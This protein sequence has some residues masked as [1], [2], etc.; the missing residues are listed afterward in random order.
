MT[1]QT[2]RG[3][4]AGSRAGEG[5]PAGAARVGGAALQ[6]QL[7]GLLVSQEQTTGRTRS[8]HCRQFRFFPCSTP[9]HSVPA[10]AAMHPAFRLCWIALLV[11]PPASAL[12]MGYGTSRRQRHGHGAGPMMIRGDKESFTD[13]YTR[14]NAGAAGAPA[15][16]ADSAAADTEVAQK[17]RGVLAA[18]QQK[19]DIPA[20]YVRML[21]GVCS[22]ESKSR[23]V[24]FR[25]GWRL[26]GRT[27]A[28]VCLR[29]PRSGQPRPISRL[30]C[31]GRRPC[32][33]V[34][35]HAASPAA[36]CAR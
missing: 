11:Q 33:C 1:T 10:A 30:C 20:D 4:P 14:R 22:V 29:L 27:S 36:M 3:L 24:L 2:G 31:A 13:Y 19:Y 28:R 35:T 12:L 15:A 26:A 6:N 21:D 7:L 18:A 25:Q 8:L 32:A 5:L 16:V 23:H 17:V 34:S 9:L